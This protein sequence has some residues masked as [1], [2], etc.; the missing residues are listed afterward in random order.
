[1]VIRK[2]THTRDG[3]LL[4]NFFGIIPEDWIYVEVV[5]Q[6]Q[7]LKGP[8]PKKRNPIIVVLHKV[9][10]EHIGTEIPR[11]ISNTT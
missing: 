4:V 7:H 1:M 2:I 5:E 10:I 6:G 3:S 11:K 8:K 9:E